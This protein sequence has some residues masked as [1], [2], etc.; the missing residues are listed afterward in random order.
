M[1]AEDRLKE[2]VDN[3]EINSLD[4]AKKEGFIHGWNEAL[5]IHSVSNQRE[6]LLSFYLYTMGYKNAQY[7]RSH[8][9]SVVDTYLRK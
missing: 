7:N 5:H 2:L 4:G 9:E 1:K 3:E 6:Q 8:A